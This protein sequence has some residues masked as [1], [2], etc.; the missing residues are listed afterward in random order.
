M[1]VQLSLCRRLVLSASALLLF[2]SC[3][4]SDDS[5]AEQPLSFQVSV[6]DATMT[7]ATVTVDPSG[8]G[9]YY[10]SSTTVP[11]WMPSAPPTRSI[12]P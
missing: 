10:V 8:E 11:R 5:A 12:S 2:G 3:S 9:T 4:D 7:G 6:S 1:Y